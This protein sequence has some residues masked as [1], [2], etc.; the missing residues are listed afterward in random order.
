MPFDLHTHSH[1]SDGTEP[2]AAVVRAAASAGLTGLALTDHDSTAGWKE[3]HEQALSS[4]ISFIP[5]MEVSCFSETGISVHLLSYLHDPHAPGLYGEIERS[6]QSRLSRAQRMVERLAGDYPITWEMVLEHSSPNATIGRPHIADALVTAGV[7][8]DRSAAFSSILTP[9]SPYYVG[10]YAPDPV[11]A[12]RLVIEAGGVPVF[13][14]PMASVRGRVVGVDL[15]REMIDAGLAGVE[16]DHRDHSEE[17]RRTLWDL[18]RE[19]GLFVTGSSD[20]HG[21]GKPN[22]L[23]EYT[24]PDAVVAQIEERATGSAVIRP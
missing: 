15:F 14:H 18:A 5:G 21:A 23:G 10:H 13:A 24:T 7:V 12:V 6:R 16:A 20:Y 22:R 11:E 8:D 17:D 3:A 1:V 9:R 2:P 19:H 4:G